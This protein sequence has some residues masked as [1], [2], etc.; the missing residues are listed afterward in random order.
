MQPIKNYGSDYSSLEFLS[1]IKTSPAI[2]I[3]TKATKAKN[4]PPITKDE[5]RITVITRV[6]MDLPNPLL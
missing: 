3:A 4:I 6:I 1:L 2:I 5:A